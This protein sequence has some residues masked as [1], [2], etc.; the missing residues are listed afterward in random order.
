MKK[1]ETKITTI[2]DKKLQNAI[3]KELGLEDKPLGELNL[4]SQIQAANDNGGGTNAKPSGNPP[5]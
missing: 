3:A 1:I 4:E 5:N 2:P